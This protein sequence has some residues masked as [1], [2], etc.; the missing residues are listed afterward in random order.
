M[1]GSKR[2]VTENEWL[3]AGKPTIADIACYPYVRLW[4]VWVQA[5]PSWVAMTV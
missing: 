2:Y 1:I 5:L 4:S 3:V